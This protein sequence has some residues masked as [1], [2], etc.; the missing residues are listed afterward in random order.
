MAVF[1]GKLISFFKST[2]MEPKPLDLL[3]LVKTK[4]PFSVTCY[5]EINMPKR[6]NI[7]IVKCN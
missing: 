7:K 3:P 5:L 1:K 4:V 6:T 2:F